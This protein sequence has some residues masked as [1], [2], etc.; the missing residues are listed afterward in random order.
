[1]H[2]ATIKTTILIS[3][4]LFYSAPLNLMRRQ[5]LQTG[6]KPFKT[7]LFLF[8]FEVS[9]VIQLYLLPGPKICLIDL[10]FD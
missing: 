4:L 10:L 5:S 8:S 1:M 3:N 7:N 6:N 2:G 9:H